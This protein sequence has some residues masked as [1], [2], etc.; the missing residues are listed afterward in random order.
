MNT[1]VVADLDIFM[2]IFK[3]D[4]IQDL[5]YFNSS[6]CSV[7]LFQPTRKY[8]L[9]D[10]CTNEFAEYTPD[11]SMIKGVKQGAGNTLTWRVDGEAI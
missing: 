7:I 11:P 3:N 1:I 6:I 9:S 4:Y 10:E 2:S 5:S 8:L